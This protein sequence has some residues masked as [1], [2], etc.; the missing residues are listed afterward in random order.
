MSAHMVS[1]HR[2]EKPAPK[3]TPIRLDALCAVAAGQV[4]K[5]YELRGP[6]LF[7]AV[8]RRRAPKAAYEWLHGNG[9][10]RQTSAVSLTGGGF[11]PARPGHHVLEAAGADA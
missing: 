11:E 3:L 4:T 5:H 7:W 6:G 8:D 1:M 10:I 9:L 2:E